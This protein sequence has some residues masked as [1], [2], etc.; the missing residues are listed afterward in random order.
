MDNRLDFAIFSS[1]FQ[2]SNIE[3]DVSVLR[4]CAIDSILIESANFEQVQ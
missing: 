1:Q 4:I 2:Q 3:Q